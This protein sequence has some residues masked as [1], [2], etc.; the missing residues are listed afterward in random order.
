MNKQVLLIGKA[1][2]IVSYTRIELLE[3]EYEVVYDK[4]PNNG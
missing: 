1:G 3:N 4:L 2:Y